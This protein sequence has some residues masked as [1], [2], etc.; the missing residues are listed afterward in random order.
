M[1]LVRGRG[2]VTY[3]SEYCLSAAT[4]VLMSGKERVVAANAKVGFHAGTLPGA[5]VEQQREMDNLVRS[6]MQSADVSEGFIK[7]VLATPPDQMWYPT[8]NEM[9]AARAVTSQ[10][11]GDRFASSWGLPDAKLDAALQDHQQ[12]PGFSRDAGV[13]TASIRKDDCRFHDSAPVW[14]VGSRSNGRSLASCCRPD[15]EVF[16]NRF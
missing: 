10:S 1:Q 8:F 16:P 2:L 15:A 3:T 6:T 4:L 7:R 5:T 12:L 11:L 9:L 14:Q 13:G